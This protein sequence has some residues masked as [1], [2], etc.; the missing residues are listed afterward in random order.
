[1][2]NMQV[3]FVHMWYQQFMIS[4]GTYKCVVNSEH[5]G[6]LV[7]YAHLSSQLSTE[8]GHS[9]VDAWRSYAAA[10]KLCEIWTKK[11]ALLFSHHQDLT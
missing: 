5:V 6:P 1:M 11:L 3:R 8:G 4:C 2:I 9:C 10:E 7:H